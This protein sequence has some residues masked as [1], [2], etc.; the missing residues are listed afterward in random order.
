M[1]KFVQLTMNGSRWDFGGA[2]SVDSDDSVIISGYTESPDF[3]LQDGLH[4]DSERS[5][6]FLARLSENGTDLI[7][8][9]LLG[10]DGEDSCYGMKML[11]DG[12]V[13]VCCFTNSDNM[14][15]IGAQQENNS[16]SQDTYFALYD[17]D[18]DSLVCASYIGGSRGDI[19]LSVD[20]FNDDLIALTGH[21]SSDDFPLENP[22]QSERAGSYDV[23]LVV[24]SISA[25]PEETPSLTDE[26][27]PPPDQFPIDQQVVGIAVSIIA[28][29][30][31]GVVYVKKRR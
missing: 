10:G 6:I 12:S 15:T 26:T 8:S 18:L 28:A 20:T 11:N 23:F 5:D 31:I 13:V 14:P 4:G 2:V 27:T 25:P 30:I 1:S 9:S 24:L 29:V 3:P 17:S 16:G 19:G 21:T 7:F 22:L